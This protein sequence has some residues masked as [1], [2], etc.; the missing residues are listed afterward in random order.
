MTPAKTERVGLV[1]DLPGAP[2][3]P[4]RVVWRETGVEIPGRYA[5]KVPVPL[6]ES[7]VS[8]EDAERYDADEGTPL[9]L[10]PVK[11]QVKDQ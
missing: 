8:K 11:G 1:L 6:D 4:H 9:K 5:P 10:V 2:N 7:G 3:S